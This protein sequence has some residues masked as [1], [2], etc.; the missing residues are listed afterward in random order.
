MMTIGR[1]ARRF[2][3]SRSTLLYYDTLG[4]LSPSDR[5]D[6]G[7]RLY[8]PADLERLEKIVSYRRMGLPLKTIK[9]ILRPET[10]GTVEVLKERL[11]ALNLEIKDCREQQALLV[12]TLGSSTV[13][14]SRLMTK[15][16]WVGLLRAAGLNQAAMWKWHSEFERVA[17]ESHQDFLESLRLSE[18]EI[19]RIRRWAKRGG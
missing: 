4:L 1:V 19:A 9:K 15:A 13:G 8:S 3:F 5:S 7:Y 11:A 6:A 16:I 17:P 18:R 14:D 12:A 2:R 10:A